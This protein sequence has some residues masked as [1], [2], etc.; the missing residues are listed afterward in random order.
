MNIRE[1]VLNTIDDLGERFGT[2]LCEGLVSYKL[3]QYWTGFVILAILTAIAIWCLIDIL[4][5]YR[6]ICRRISNEGWKWEREDS[7]FSCRFWSRHHN[8]E[9]CSEIDNFRVEFFLHKVSTGEVWLT[10]KGMFKLIAGGVISISCGISLIILLVQIIQC[11][12]TPEMFVIDYIVN[13]I[14]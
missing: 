10:W 6:G 14:G 13:H 11:Y 7:P 1:K 8:W 3:I 2:D 9:Y 4:T 5:S 12:T